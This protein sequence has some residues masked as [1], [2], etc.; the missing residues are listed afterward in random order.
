MLIRLVYLLMIRV[1]GWLA[2]LTRSDTSKDTK[3]LV[4]RCASVER[5][6]FVLHVPGLAV[7][8]AIAAPRGQI[9]DQS[10]LCDAGP[11]PFTGAVLVAEERRLDAGLDAVQAMLANLGRSGV[12][13]ISSVDSRDSRIDQLSESSPGGSR[14]VAFGRGR[15]GLTG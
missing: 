6:A 1:F 15:H 12:L 10:P 13:I 8:A 3:I 5:A 14:D 9:K 2:L 7:C 4:L 11:G